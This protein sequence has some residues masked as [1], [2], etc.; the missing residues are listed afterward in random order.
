M[1]QFVYQGQTV[2]IKLITGQ[3]MSD[4]LGALNGTVAIRYKKPD[5]TTGTWVATSSDPTSGNIEY[6]TATANLDQE[7]VWSL[8]A[9]WNKASP[10]GTY[11]GKTV[12]MEV[13]GLGKGC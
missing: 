1:A 4:G 8:N 9:V 3:D 11:Y 2:E 12:C 6:V 10:L 7:G 5:G 13:R